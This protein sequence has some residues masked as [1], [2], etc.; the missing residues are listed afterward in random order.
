[1]ASPVHHYLVLYPNI[2]TLRKVY[3]NYIELQLEEQ[4]SVILFLPYYDTTDKLREILITKE[5]DVS[6]HE[7]SGLLVLLDFDKIIDNPYLGVPAAFG[8]KEFVNKVQSRIT[9]KSLIVIA[10]M[11][12]HNHLDKVEDL[13]DCEKLPHTDYQI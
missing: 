12:I 7:R 3:A 9:D 11:S 10:D 1:M 2:E 8:L 6:R 13:L 5:V 4:D